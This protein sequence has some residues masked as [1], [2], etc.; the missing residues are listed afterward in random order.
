MILDS[1]NQNKPQHRTTPQKK[2]LLSLLRSTREHP[3]AAW[4]RDQLT[5]YFPSL[6]LGTVY[7]NL[8]VLAEEGLVKIVYTGQDADRFDADTSV[9]YHV[10][11][12]QC[13]RVD[14]IDLETMAGI[15]EHAAQLSGYNIETH[16]I[17][18]EGICP[19]CTKSKN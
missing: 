1:N 9:H 15:N 5:P 10:N 12:T 3:T 17:I 16:S 6:S 14:D 8:S 19:N 4:L 7:R 18:F 11:C 2:A 13:G